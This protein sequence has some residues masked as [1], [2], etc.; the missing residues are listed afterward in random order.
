MEV[1][2]FQRLT[3]SNY[4]RLITD[5]SIYHISNLKAYVASNLTG[6]NTKKYENWESKLSFFLLSRKLYIEL[7][8]L[9]FLT[10]FTSLIILFLWEG[11]FLKC[12]AHL[13]YTR[14]KHSVFRHGCHTLIH[15]S[16]F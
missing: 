9:A 4:Y 15:G 10:I 14:T 1:F 8:L 12:L 2:K 16:K 7:R 13:I 11:L 3:I 6:I 5:V